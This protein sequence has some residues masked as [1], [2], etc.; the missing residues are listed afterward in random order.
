[1]GWQKKSQEHDWGN[2]DDDG[3]KTNVDSFMKIINEHKCLTLEGNADGT[4]AAPTV[5]LQHGLE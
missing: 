2:E 1:M 3:V 5:M 4:S